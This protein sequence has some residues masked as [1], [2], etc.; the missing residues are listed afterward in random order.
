MGNFCGIGV[1]Y[2]ILHRK[3]SAIL[4]RKANY[5]MYP[6]F[7][8]E[9]TVRILENQNHTLMEQAGASIF[10][11]HSDENVEMGYHWI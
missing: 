1:S 10:I 11:S 9:F 2:L 5:W 3:I 6:G 7:L 4:L 8:P